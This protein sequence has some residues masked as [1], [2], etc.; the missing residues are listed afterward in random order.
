MT[1][2]IAVLRMLRMLERRRRLRRMRGMMMLRLRLVW[3]HVRREGGVGWQG[4]VE[5]NV[6]DVGN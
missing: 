6:T 3:S 5:G 1:A 4:M 2:L